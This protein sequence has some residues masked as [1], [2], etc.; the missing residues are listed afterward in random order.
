MVSPINRSRTLPL[1]V[2]RGPLGVAATSPPIVV[3]ATISSTASRCPATASCSCSR[4][5][6]SPASAVAIRSPA[7]CSTSRF[8]FAVS[9][10]RSSRSGGHPQ[11]LLVPAPRATTASAFSAATRIT[12]A[13]SAVQVGA[14]TSVGTTPS[15]SSRAP[16]SRTLAQTSTRSALSEVTVIGRCPS[17]RLSQAGLD[18]RMRALALARNLTAQPRRRKHLAWV[19]HRLRVEGAANHLHGVE[20][21]IGEHPRHVLG[22]V[23]TDT[24]LTGDGPTMRDAQIENRAGDLLSP[25]GLSGI[26]TVEKHHRVQ[27]AVTGVENVGHPHPGLGRQPRHLGQHLRQRRPRKHARTEERAGG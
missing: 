26:G 1:A 12:A 13:V 18:Q 16:A 23:R 27:V 17:E 14:A 8:M 24:V 10:T 7:A 20:V 9:T 15:T 3:P 2:R 19:G 6:G 25:F 11:P 5:N 21:L 22:L 4:A